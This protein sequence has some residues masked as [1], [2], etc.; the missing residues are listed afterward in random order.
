MGQICQIHDGQWLFKALS[1]SKP[2]QKHIQNIEDFIWRFCVNY[3]TWNQVTC[4]IVYPIPRC[5][6]AVENR[7][8]AFGCGSTKPSWAI[9]NLLLRPNL[10]RSL[11]SKDSI[12]LDG[13]IP[14]CPLS[15][16]TAPPPSSWW[17]M[18]SI[19]YGRRPPHQLVCPLA[20]ML[21][22]KLS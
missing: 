15:R 22:T 4:L 21:I 17:F 3:I 6:G 20:L 19:A 9:I 1:A 18:M 12:Q 8:K 13:H 5:D 7:L 16:L 11:L 2:N 14:S 10:K